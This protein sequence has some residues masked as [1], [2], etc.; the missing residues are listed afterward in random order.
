MDEMLILVDKYDNPIG[1]AGK[2]DVHQKGML[3]RAF[4]IFVFDKKGNLLLQKRA[5]TKYHSAGLW[6][7]SCC[8]HPRVGESLDTAAHR[9]LGEEMGFD[10]PLKKVLS[11]IYHATL[12][13]TL[14][15]YEYDHVFIGQFDKEPI[16]NP[17]E[18]SDYKWVS[19]LKLRGLINKDPGEYTVWFKKIIDGLLN[20]DIKDWQRQL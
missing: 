9:R 19:P 20:Q 15:E 13:N 10:C 14:I 11:F 18:V 17:D 7:N 12:P 16:I 1:S 2:M 6:T 3:H 8:G 4:S 5:A